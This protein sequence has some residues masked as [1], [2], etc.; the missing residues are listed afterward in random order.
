MKKFYLIRKSKTK[1]NKSLL[2][3]KPDEIPRCARNDKLFRV[4]GDVWG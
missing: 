1:Y 2:S 3:V 4:I